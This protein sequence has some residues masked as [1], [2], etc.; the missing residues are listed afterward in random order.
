MFRSEPHRTL[1]GAWVCASLI[2]SFAAR[3]WAEETFY[4]EGDA[5]WHYLPGTQEASSPDPTLW[6]ALDFED[7]DWEEGPAPLGSG[8]DDVAT[9][10][11]LLDPPP[12]GN[13]SSIFLRQ[14]FLASDLARIEKLE[15]RIEYDDGIV[16]WLNGTE[17]LRLNMTGSTGDPVTIADT[18]SASSRAG[19]GRGEVYDLSEFTGLLREGENVLAV[20]LFNQSVSGR[21]LW[22][23]LELL[24]P[25]GPDRTPPKTRSIFPAPGTVVR[26]LDRI[27]VTFDE[28]V[29]GLD[30]TDLLIGGRPADAAGGF[31]AG[32]WTF[33]FSPPEPG[34]IEMRWAS[35]HGIT[36]TAPIP[37]AF[38]GE[39]F[40]YTL[41][42][43]APLPN[44]VISEVSSA[45]VDGP[46]D[47]DGDRSDWIE[48]ENRDTRPVN[49]AG[50]SLSDDPDRPGRW[51]FP[52]VTL[53]PR[54]FLLVFASGKNRRTADEELHADFRLSSSGETIGLYDAESPRSAITTLEVPE[55]RPGFSWGLLDS[56]DAEFSL[57]SNPTPG[58]PN[59]ETSAVS[60]FAV[61]PVFSVAHGFFTSGF[62]LELTTTTPDATIRYTLD[63]SEP[64]PGLGKI[65]AD[66]IPIAGS[67]DRPAAVVRAAAFAQTL[68][69]SRTVTRTYVFPRET[70]NQPRLPEGF[71]SR[72]NAAAADYE[73]DPDVVAS[74]GPDSMVE[75]LLDLPSV[76]LAGSMEDIFGT[77]G[78][79]SNS[80]ASGVTWERPGSVELIYPDGRE[81]F[82][83]P[84][85]LRMQGGASRIPDRSP[86]H[87]FRVLFKSIYGLAELEYPIFPDSDVRTFDTLIFRAGYNNSWIHNTAQQR[88]RALYIR[89]QWMR[90]SLLDMGQPQSHGTFVHLYVN[91][92]YWG[93]HNL[94]ERP[95]APFAADHFGGDDSEYDAL[96]SANPVD[97]TTA[98]WQEL[99]SAAGRIT[100]DP[101]SYLAIAEI[102]DLENLADYMLVNVYGANQDW[103]SHNWY[104]ARRNVPGGKWH[105]FS[106]D[107]ERVLEGTSENRT[108]VADGNSP[109]LIYS[110]LR[111][112]P[113]FQLLFADRVE[114]HLLHDGA[115]SAAGSTA[116]FLE[117]ADELERAVLAESARW[118][119]YRRP[120]PYTRDGEWARERSRLINA[121]FPVRPGILLTQLRGL[122]LYP[123]IDAP[124]LSQDGGDVPQG[125]ELAITSDPG[126]A[127]V[128]W[129]TTDGSD[130]RVPFSGEPS[131][132]ARE[133]TGTIAIAETT[134]VRARTLADGTWSALVEALFRITE[135]DDRE[136]VR[137]SEIAYHPDSAPE[138]EFVEVANLSL[139]PI[140][141]SGWRFTDGVRFTFPALSILQPGEHA[142]IIRDPIRFAER[143]PDVPTRG[144]FHGSLDD[145]GERLTL[146]DATGVVVDSVA[147]DDDALWPLGPDGFGFTLVRTDT[148][149]DPDVPDAWRAS[150][151]LGGSPGAPDPDS[152]IDTIL[153]SEV[154]PEVAAPYEAAVELWNPGASAVDVSGW[155]LSDGR[156]GLEGL[157][158]YA[159]PAGNVLAPGGRLVLYA[160]DFSDPGDPLGLRLPRSG[161]AVYLTAVTG[162]AL[163]GHV[164]GIVYEPQEDSGGV[165]FG[166][167]ETS[168]GLEYVPLRRPTF[169]VDDPAS[170]EDFRSGRGAPNSE[171]RLGPVILNEIAYH[172]P[173]D[174]DVFE[175]VELYNPTSQPVPLFDREAG[176]G[177]LIRGL[178][179]AATGEL[180]FE[181]TEGSSIPARGYLVLAPVD[182]ELFRVVYL[183]HG[184]PVPDG[185]VVIGPYGGALSNAGERLR[186]LRPVSGSGTNALFATVD[187]VRYGDTTPWPSDA[188]GFG[189][190]LERTRTNDWGDDPASWAASAIR[191]DG[192]VGTPGAPNDSAPVVGFQVPG[193]L[194]QDARLN[195]SDPV[196]LLRYLF[197]AIEPGSADLPCVGDEANLAVAD[198]NGD[199]RLDIADPI[200]LLRYLFLGGPEPAG[201]REC[202]P[203]PGCPSICE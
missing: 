12:R 95:S 113:E 121:Y 22:L 185:A 148:S 10:F 21:D 79:Y 140:D 139:H 124:A 52:E 147:W 133:V 156:G 91:G 36:D 137:L 170:V 150:A 177:W 88:E 182:P 103:P 98:A 25:L 80:E 48:I 43:D 126:D 97:G 134:L 114:K 30:A 63:G 117:R 178:L 183:V 153:I 49:L 101:Q 130:P 157:A 94:V 102:L 106:W 143:Y 192:T 199:G 74:A 181:F 76:S 107:A 179:D 20:H 73:M 39:S 13:Y 175:F 174:A 201:G 8:R 17:V 57:F 55:L 118:G 166:L 146:R 59:D 195:V 188:D 155:Y 198:A 16:A 111:L 54:E 1:A 112:H 123:S 105:F 58:A 138:H 67:P 41:D 35:G 110:R 142:V 187:T 96:N 154:L 66:P 92:V 2:A 15:V 99:Q 44:L 119:D 159:I 203:V 69:P 132:S 31:G 47:E 100:A 4:I 89:D 196:R 116:R 9:D 14:R 125:F 24:D 7:G 11:E 141:V 65:Y 68:L 168:I 176:R 120:T 81:G 18:A 40:R 38:A 26:R 189:A 163:T 109:A 160:G 171:P 173:E 28:P 93:L 62:E 144:L 162:G 33:R 27:Q 56:P 172:P 5:S 85:G 200:H 53:G 164:T 165:S 115:L 50:H 186:L 70:P 180:D 84:C 197:G 3:G 193:D 64:G 190:S 151:E 167:H 90:D 78:I 87:S 75:A 42:P 149:G 135:A 161:G 158:K 191:G 6:R 86:K 61:D 29:T 23:R 82:S 104:A 46:V 145:G 128:V 152:E 45:N 169:G 202:V 19:P 51:V 184:R 122:R 71:P 194:D 131:A 129:Y 34:E 136:S 60:G 108:T 83:V 127:G 77:R 72:W 37:N 32:P